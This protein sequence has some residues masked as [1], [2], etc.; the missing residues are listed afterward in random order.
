MPT[1][2]LPL[3]A[4]AWSRQ[5]AT[6]TS[7][8]YYYGLWHPTISVMTLVIGALF[9]RETKDADIVTNSRIAKMSI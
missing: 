3:R 8:I 6:S 9:P 1:R 5:T 4:T 2:S 7:I